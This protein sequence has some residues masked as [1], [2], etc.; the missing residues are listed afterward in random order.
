MP[1]ELNCHGIARRNGEKQNTGW[2]KKTE[3]EPSKGRNDASIES[4]T[5]F[6]VRG[7][8]L[9]QRGLLLSCHSLA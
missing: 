1:L 3:Q 8:L 2:L 7:G 6:E 9:V 5:N 4:K